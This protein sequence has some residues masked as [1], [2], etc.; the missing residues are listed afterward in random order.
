MNALMSH[1][2]LKID[3]IFLNNLTQ[4]IFSNLGNCLQN[5][6]LE[7]HFSFF[8]TWP[9]FSSLVYRTRNN[10]R[11]LHA[12][13]RFKLIFATW[14]NVIGDKFRPATL[15]RAMDKKGSLTSYTAYASRQQGQRYKLSEKLQRCSNSCWCACR[16]CQ[17]HSSS[18][19]PP[20]V[21]EWFIRWRSWCLW[22]TVSVDGPDVQ[23]WS[24]GTYDSFLEQSF[25]CFLQ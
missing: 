13:K 7:H 22:Y 1:Q 24:K 2:I 19:W 5:L 21:H 14:F 8:V 18:W 12:S 25:C 4:L 23:S 15:Y 20:M 17:I 6:D 3:F 9:F 16:K 11:N 10:Y